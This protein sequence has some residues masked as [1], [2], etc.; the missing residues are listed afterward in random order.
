MSN[1][2]FHINQGFT[3]FPHTRKYVEIILECS[4]GGITRVITE[5]EACVLLESPHCTNK[6]ATYLFFQELARLRSA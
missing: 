3:I 5:E 1:G 4:Q 2:S 6:E